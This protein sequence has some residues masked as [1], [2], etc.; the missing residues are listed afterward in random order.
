VFEEDDGSVM[1][2]AVMID[3]VTLGGVVVGEVALPDV[4][5]PGRR[6]SFSGAGYTGV[7]RIV[8]TLYHGNFV[9]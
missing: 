7:K 6:D 4:D 8:Q 3:V 5:V 2:G 1:V 9:T